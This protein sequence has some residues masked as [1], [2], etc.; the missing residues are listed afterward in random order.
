MTHEII[1]R[2]IISFFAI[3]FSINE[4]KFG[5]IYRLNDCKITWRAYS[6]LNFSKKIIV[7]NLF[8]NSPEG[9]IA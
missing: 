7:Y 2:L 9:R 8:K 5:T 4:I 6:F 1:F 3:F